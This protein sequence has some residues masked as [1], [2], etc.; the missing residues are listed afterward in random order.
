VGLAHEVWLLLVSQ[1]D[2]KEAAHLRA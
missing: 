2:A 1:G